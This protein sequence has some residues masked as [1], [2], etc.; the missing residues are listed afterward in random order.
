[1]SRFYEPDLTETPDSPDAS[2][3]AGILD[4]HDR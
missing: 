2:N 1:M 4:G 3:A